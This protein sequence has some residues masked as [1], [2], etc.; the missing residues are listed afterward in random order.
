MKKTFLLKNGWW[1][2]GTFKV[3]SPQTTHQP[4]F[5]TTFWILAP[6]LTIII[7]LIIMA[8]RLYQSNKRRY[9]LN[10]NMEDYI[11]TV[12]EMGKSFEQLSETM[13]ELSAFSSLEGQQRDKVRLAIWRINTLQNSLQALYKLEKE[14][15]WDTSPTIVP[16]SVPNT[17]SHKEQPAVAMFEEPPYPVMDAISGNDEYFLE[18][19]FSIIRECYVDPSFT[20]DTLSQKMGMSRSSFYNKIKA[21]SGQAPAD[22]IRQYRMERAKELLKSKQYSISEVALKAGFTDVKYFR[23]VFRKK[24]NRSPSE[25]AKSAN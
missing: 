1:L 2:K 12:K 20:V 14:S 21:I 23:D 16:K 24:Y 3:I 13:N 4:V 22:F 18:K 5:I 7:I 8:I 25:Y 17:T 9:L 11:K 15:D 6:Y 19:V 10:R